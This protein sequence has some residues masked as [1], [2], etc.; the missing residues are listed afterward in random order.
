MFNKLF[1]KN[2]HTQGLTVLKHFKCKVIQ[3]RFNFGK[4]RNVGRKFEIE[5]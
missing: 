5:R 3:K 1:F 4:K 2:T